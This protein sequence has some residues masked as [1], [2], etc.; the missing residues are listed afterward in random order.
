MLIIL[1]YIRLVLLWIFTSKLALVSAEL[2]TNTE[3]N[4]DGLLS[5]DRSWVK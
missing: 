1:C 5:Q 2:E 4:R 3:R